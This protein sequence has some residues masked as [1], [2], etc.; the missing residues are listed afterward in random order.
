MMPERE[1]LLQCIIGQALRYGIVGLTSNLV[2]Y[3]LYLLLTNYGLDYKLTMSLLFA[4][5]TVQT[6]LLNKRWTFTHRGFYQSSFTK[7]LSTYGAVYLLNM[8]ALLFFVDYLR[9]PH[10]IVQGVIVITLAVMLFLVQCP[11][12]NLTFSFL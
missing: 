8:M 7:Y 10:Q 5:G 12:N 11:V 9:L 2:L 1:N 6:F 3:L 4:C